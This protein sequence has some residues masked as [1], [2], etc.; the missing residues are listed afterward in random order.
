V[1]IIAT[2]HVIRRE[3]VGCIFVLRGD[4]PRVLNILHFSLAQG[5][6]SYL[7]NVLHFKRSI[8]HHKRKTRNGAL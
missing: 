7:R 6:T 5:A 4:A 2:I 8:A 1:G 3:K